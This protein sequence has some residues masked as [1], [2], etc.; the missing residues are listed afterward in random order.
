LHLRQTDPSCHGNENLKIITKN[1]YNWASVGDMFLILA[2]SMGFS[3]VAIPTVSFALTQTDPGCHGNENVKILRE[4]WYNW[5]S[6]RDMFVI[7]VPSRGF[8]ASANLTV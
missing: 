5:A 1:G 2:P 8:L 3:M 7:L 6:M 4:N